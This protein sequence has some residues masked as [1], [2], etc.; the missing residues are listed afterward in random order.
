LAGKESVT[1]YTDPLG[2]LGCANDVEPNNTP[3]TATPFTPGRALN[4]ALSPNSDQDWW[5][6]TATAGVS[7]IFVFPQNSVPLN[8]HYSMDI[9]CS[10]GT[11]HLAMGGDVTPSAQGGPGGGQG[12]IVFTAPASGTYYFRMA[13]IPPDPAGAYLVYTGTNNVPGPAGERGRDQRDVFVATSTDGGANWNTPVRM[14]DD[15]ALFDDWLP[16]VAV[17]R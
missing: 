15:A 13:G 1:W 9:Y 11:T 4:G 5:S 3:G 2:G 17:G 8:M 7:Y 6:F 16:E 12:N 10:N 14:N